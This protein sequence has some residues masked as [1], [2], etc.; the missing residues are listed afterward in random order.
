VEGRNKRSAGAPLRFVADRLLEAGCYEA[1]T[2]DGGQTAAMLFMGKNVTSPGIYS[3]YQ[4]ARKQQD[5][6]GIGRW[7]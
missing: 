2:L 4:K 1:F 7:E 5:I 3:G 6:L